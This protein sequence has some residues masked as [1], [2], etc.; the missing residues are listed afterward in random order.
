MMKLREAR[1]RR[2]RGERHSPGHKR[3]H[4]A[5]NRAVPTADRTACLYN[6][7]RLALHS[8]CSSPMKQTG[9]ARHTK[10]SSNLAAFQSKVEEYFFIIKID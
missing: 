5:G 6:E 4:G 3:G 8:P 7:E 2:S 10:E 1:E 9:K